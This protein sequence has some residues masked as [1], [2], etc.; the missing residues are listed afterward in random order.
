M[1]KIGF[2]CR[3]FVLIKTNSI[4]LSSKPFCNC[5]FSD[6]SSSSGSVVPIDIGI[7]ACIHSS[8]SYDHTHTCSRARAYLK[9]IANEC[10]Q[11]IARQT[12]L[13]SPTTNYNA[14]ALGNST[15]TTTTTPRGYRSTGRVRC[16]W[17]FHAWSIVEMDDI[18]SNV[19]E[20]YKYT[21]ACIRE[22]NEPQWWRREF[23]PCHWF[24]MDQWNGTTSTRQWSAGK[25]HSTAHVHLV[26]DIL[27]NMLAYKYWLSANRF[28][29]C[30]K[31]RADKCC[32]NEHRNWVH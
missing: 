1:F 14:H 4:R 20:Q 25:A 7:C 15:T 6:S 3:I 22:A 16:E 11:T 27:Y 28:W 26:I 31:V 5:A 18:Q 30:P 21:Y 17:T 9:H 13:R 32:I 23:P 24:R 29:N 2:S 12:E 8:L 19:P 10:Q